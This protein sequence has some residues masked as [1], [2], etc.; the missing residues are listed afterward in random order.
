[1]QRFFMGDAKGLSTPLASHLKLSKTLCPQTKAKEEQ[2]VRIPYT[3]AV[4]SVMYVMVC[5]R[6]DIAHMVI[7]VSRYMSN[8]GKGH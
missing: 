3:S 2:I 8:P 7:L 5:L 1:M 6:P 4:G